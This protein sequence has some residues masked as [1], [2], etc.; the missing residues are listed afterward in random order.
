MKLRL[1]ALLGIVSFR[2]ASAESW[3]ALPAL[4][5]GL[6]ASAIAVDRESRL[7]V[8]GGSHWSEGERR[9]AAALLRLA[10]DEGRREHIADLPE[11]RAYEPAAPPLPVN[12]ETDAYE[13]RD[14]FLRHA[15]AFELH[16]LKRQRWSH[17]AEETFFAQET[18]EVRLRDD[19]VLRFRRVP[20]GSY[21]D[22]ITP[23]LKERVLQIP[24]RRGDMRRWEGMFEI[25]RRDRVSVPYDF[26]MS[27]TIVSNA[28][29]AFFVRKTGYKTAVS[30][31][32]T[33]WV[34]DADAQW[35][36]GFANEWRQQLPP[37]SDPDHPVV[38]VSWFDAM[39]FAAWLS[40]RSGVVFRVPTQE[41][42][43]LA[44]HAPNRTDVWL[45]PWGNE[46]EGIGRRMN[47]G[48]AELSAYAWIHEQLS[49]GHA[50]SSPVRAYPPNARGLHDMLGN[51]WVWNWT[52]RAQY[53]ARAHGD[54]VARPASLDTLGAGANEALSMSGGCYLARLTHAN[55]HAKMS[56]P[57]LD[58]A[59][60][61][62]FRLVAV[63]AA[64][65]GL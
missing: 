14:Q 40:E 48:T 53:D 47:F 12:R 17:E 65:S 30:R 52:N 24:N 20:G 10:A 41:E 31:Y 58:G 50:Y 35:L 26:F 37:L 23:E 49:D 2:P 55:L 51:V 59:E 1:L 36:Q 54:R 13:S 32:E 9:L 39:A 29:F 22:G 28:M 18:Q 60:D 61:I 57:A 6:A 21:I 15:A 38:Q 11:P 33:G 34:V 4:P 44:A 45:F 63:R 42:W 8:A 56:H 5:R 3:T 7:V 46:L 25:D 27:E 19:V 62:G 64:D 16:K 43:L